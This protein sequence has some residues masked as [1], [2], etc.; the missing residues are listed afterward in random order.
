MLYCIHDRGAVR[1]TKQ[2]KR[3]T[4]RRGSARRSASSSEDGLRLFCATK[5]LST[6]PILT[7]KS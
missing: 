1:S 5:C 7:I 4:F 6:L 3:I 2:V